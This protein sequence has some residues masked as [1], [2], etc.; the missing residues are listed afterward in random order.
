LIDYPQPGVVML[1]EQGRETI[2]DMAPPDQEEIWQ[3]IERTCSGPEKKILKALLEHAGE[4]EISKI[5]LAEK[6]G[7]SPEGGAFGNPIGALRSKGLLDYPRQGIVRASDW[8]F[9]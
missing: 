5:D 9:I 8:L 3:R 1:T 2:G 6:S 4:G 7:Y